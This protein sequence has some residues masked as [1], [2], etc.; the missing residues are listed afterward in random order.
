MKL[1]RLAPYPEDAPIL[2]AFNDDFCGTQ[3]SL[4]VML[5]AGTPYYFRIG[6]NND[7]CNG[8]IDF[9]FSY[10]GPVQGCT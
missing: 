3:A 8:P 9:S 1:P 6:D 10:V 2:C 5:V 7:D 4:N